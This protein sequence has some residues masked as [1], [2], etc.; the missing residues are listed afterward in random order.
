MSE[1]VPILGERKLNDQNIPIEN[2]RSLKAITE[3]SN[4]TIYNK[5]PP[6]PIFKEKEDDFFETKKSFNIENENFPQRRRKT[7]EGIQRRKNKEEDSEDDRIKDEKIE[8]MKGE[9]E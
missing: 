7:I 5:F 2:S 6:K 1:E 4:E 9:N 3:I 8:K